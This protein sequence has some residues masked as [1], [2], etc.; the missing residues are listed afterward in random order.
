MLAHRKGSVGIDKENEMGMFG[1]SYPPGCSGPPDEASDYDEEDEMKTVK[2]VKITEQYIQ[3][4]D[5][6][7]LYSNHDQECCESHYL[8]F[9]HLTLGDFEGLEF[10]ISGDDFFEKIPGYGIALLPIYG[11][12][13]RIPG[14]SYNNGFYSNVLEL[15]LFHKDRCTKIY[16]ITECQDTGV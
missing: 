13:V 4:D 5:G 2:V 6:A 15:H 1:W 12:P 3:F 16:C 10:D 9:Q 8:S 7:M 11:H 14:Y